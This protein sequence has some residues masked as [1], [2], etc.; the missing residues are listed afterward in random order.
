MKIVRVLI[1]I[2]AAIIVLTILKI[3]LTGLIAGLG[4]GG[5]IVTLA[6]QDTAKNLFGGFVIF[7]DKPFAVGDWIQMDSFEGTIEDITFRTTRIRTFENSLLNVPNSIISNASVINWSKMES[8]RYKVNLRIELN[9]PVEKLKILKTRVE[10]ML[11]KRE[12]ILDDS[13]IV[14]FDSMDEN[15]INMLVYTYTNSVGYSNYLEEVE[16]INYKIMK[17]IEEEQIKIAHDTTNIYV[18]N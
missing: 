1:Y 11:Y 5:I 7:I 8:R 3:D 16:E 13:T 12:N 6:A 17:I 2:I 15:G 14:R 10:E 4:V 18:K 9:T